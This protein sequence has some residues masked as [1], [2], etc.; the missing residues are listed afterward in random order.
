[1]DAAPGAGPGEAY[2]PTYVAV[3]QQLG[4][5]AYGTVH[6]GVH[7]GTGAQVAVKEFASGVGGVAE[8][9]TELAMLEKLV[10]PRVVRVLGSHVGA[11]DGRALMYLEFMPGGSLATLMEKNHG[12]LWEGLVRR[13]A[14]DATCGVAF[15]HGRGVV[16]RDIKPQNLL[17]GADGRVKV[18][19]FGCCRELAQSGTG[20][21]TMGTPRYMAPEAVMGKAVFASDVWALAATVTELASFVPPWSDVVTSGGTIA[22]L[23]HIG[24]V[25]ERGDSPQS[26]PTIPEV[27]SPVVQ[28]ALRRCFAA[29]ACDRPSCAE[30]L[31]T[32]FLED[33]EVALPGAET[34][35][36]Y[37]ATRR[38]APLPER[39]EHHV[40]VIHSISVGSTVDTAASAPEATTFGTTTDRSW[41]TSTLRPSAGCPGCIICAV[42]GKRKT[43][44]KRCRNQAPRY[45]RLDSSI[46]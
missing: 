38:E 41:E 18:A 45:G 23:F 24:N 2:N 33:V 21:N 22:L 13:V 37:N 29:A 9:T 15:L 14:L 35:A 1:M 25:A 4:K 30:L 12:R 17:I 42:R 31:E 34:I 5:G 7:E 6:L 20:T 3:G 36:A 32:R 11:E 8:L 43:K 28:E 16:H 27:L 40:D 46:R 26:H 39:A 10:H 44:K 19:D